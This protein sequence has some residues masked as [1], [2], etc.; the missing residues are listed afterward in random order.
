MGSLRLPPAPAWPTAKGMHRALVGLALAAC[1]APTELPGQFA[2]ALP[3]PRTDSVAIADELRGR[4]ERELPRAL[5][6]SLFADTLALAIQAA[7]RLTAARAAFCD[8]MGERGDR[9][10]AIC[11]DAI[12]PDS[13]VARGSAAP[14][15]ET[16]VYL[17]FRPPGVHRRGEIVDYL[18]Q[19]GG[20]EG[21]RLFSRFAANVSDKEAYVVS[22]AISGLTGR[23]LFGL[24]YAAVVVK[25]DAADS[26]TRKAIEGDRGSVMRMIN[27]GGTIAGRFQFPLHAQAGPTGQSASS[28]YATAGLIG[29]LGQSDSLRFAGSVNAEFIMSLAIRDLTETASLLGDLILGGRVGYAFSESPI[30]STADAKGLPYAQL[31]VGLR[32]NADISLSALVTWALADEMKNLSPKL[33]VNF[34]AVR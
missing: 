3:R 1:L 17:R 34:A 22:D 33:I 27:N 15:K 26:T 23:V 11:L 31:A 7:P 10:L 21:L 13:M 18:R 12:D 25:D 24:T 5:R 2:T 29:P 28:I 20:G 8:R 32:Q 14:K 16:V 9:L 19:A 4:F 6:D 30:V